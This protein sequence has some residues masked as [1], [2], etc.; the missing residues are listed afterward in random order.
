MSQLSQQAPPMGAGGP[1]PVPAQ[2]PKETLKLALVMSGG[3]SLAVWMGGVT[4]EIHQLCVAGREGAHPVDTPELGSTGLLYRQLLALTHCQASVDVISGVSAGGINGAA[5]AVALLHDGDFGQLRQLWLQTAALNNLLRPPLGLNPG[6][7]LQGEAYFLPALEQ[8]LQILRRLPKPLSAGQQAMDLRLSTTLLTG[9]QGRHVDDLGSPVND[10]DYRAQFHFQHL[11]AGS[12]FGANQPWLAA[13]ARAAR[14][15]ASFPFAFEPSKVDAAV[16]AAHLRAAGGE[17]LMPGQRYVIDGGLL[18]NKPFAGALQAISAMPRTG[19][20]RRVLAY[21]CPD[22]GDGPQGHTNQGMPALSQ[23]L[24]E[25]VFGIPQSQTI[26]DQLR[27]IQRHNDKVRGQRD[28]LLQVASALSA[29]DLDDLASKLFAVYRHRRLVNTFALFIEPNLTQAIGKLGR[30]SLNHLQQ[31][32]CACTTH[33][34]WLPAEW[35]HDRGRM[36]GAAQQWQW[37][38]FPLEFAMSVLLELAR[39]AESLSGLPPREPLHESPAEREGRWRCMQGI[40]QGWAK[41]NTLSAQVKGRRG[42]E[43][44]QWTQ[45]CQALRSAWA[46]ARGGQSTPGAQDVC[47][48]KL[49][50]AMN[51]HLGFLADAARQRWCKSQLA[52][53]C[54]RLRE[55]LPLAAQAAERARGAAAAD[56][57]QTRQAQGVWRLCELL[58]GLTHA[59][60]PAGQE[61]AAR[62]RSQPPSDEQL[63]FRLLQ[64]EVVCYAFDDHEAMEQDILIELVQISGN[65]RSPLLGAWP[66]EGAVSGEGAW[67]AQGKLRGL[68]LAH[69]A[70]FY[71][72]SWRS[73]DWIWGRLD[74]ADRLVQVLLNPDR[75]R[76]QY[77]G[78]KAQALAAIEALALGEPDAPQAAL[79]RQRWQAL[80]GAL[81]LAGE[82]AFL[83]AP[84]GALPD[85][86]PACAAAIVCRLHLLIMQEELPS[87]QLAI[88]HDQAQGAAQGANARQLLA[89]G[90]VGAR[91]TPQHA[92]EALR[93]GLLQDEELADEVGSDLFTRSIAHVTA[94]VQNTIASA[95][96]KLGPVSALF[97]LLK[98]PV[99]GFNFMAQTLTR[100]S[101]TAAALHASM[102]SVGLVIVL[103]SSLFKTLDGES[104]RGLVKLGWLM[105]VW[106][107]LF[108]V[109]RF[110]RIGFVMV[111][112]VAAMIA[113]SRWSATGWPVDAGHVVEAVLPVLVVLGLWFG[114]LRSSMLQWALGLAAIFVFATWSTPQP[115]WEQWHRPLAP[116]ERLALALM[117]VL[118]IAIWQATWP[119]AALE[120]WLRH[121]VAMR[122]KR[123]RRRRHADRHAGS[124]RA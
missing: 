121:K 5:L 3:V 46:D 53:L 64:L 100:Q 40:Q 103:G 42:V 18:D 102:L 52:A 117:A 49:A 89:M 26:S 91:A 77:Q 73:N 48:D 119:G 67:L 62:L 38:L 108:S 66:G 59:P 80:G 90:Q 97:A 107:T 74:G 57:L 21:I 36:V 29:A 96:A 85:T 15:S 99:Q 93:M 2:E 30:R 69:F 7:L 24:G 114:L 50:L 61:L 14:S 43:R 83:D 68:A 76:R 109:L 51:G 106:G 35:H 95:S 70:A 94:S 112:M 23:V 32:F 1:P 22:P 8:A 6:S 113:L 9:H 4:R 87:L 37:G 65:V 72:Q 116:V 120:Q 41:I 25:A 16:S 13:L 118:L 45:Y 92:L 84:L 27:E 71:K 54:Q 86:L 88:A 47:L 104:A 79:L 111:G 28:S 63:T 101:R 124:G 98:L 20:M 58:G 81:A 105:L 82:L 31:Q 10:V 19:P 33:E 17:D 12:S 39:T 60:E 110:A 123:V 115:L 34:A 44:S 75:L 56:A 78:R 11:E 122:R 55:L